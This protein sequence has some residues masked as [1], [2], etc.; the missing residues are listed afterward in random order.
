MTDN[1]APTYR[2]MR[3]D[4]EH[5]ALVERRWEG[6]QGWPVGECSKCGGTGLG[7]AVIP[8]R[9]GGQCDKCRGTGRNYG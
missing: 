3:E 5:L 2:E 1:P 8:G 4:P 7:H 6:M 9:G